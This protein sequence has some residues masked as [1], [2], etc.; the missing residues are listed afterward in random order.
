MVP[1]LVLSEFRNNPLMVAVAFIVIQQLEGHVVVPNVMGRSVGVHPL[2][3]IFGLLIGEAIAGIP[4]VLLSIPMVVIVKE[5]VTFAGDYLAGDTSE[6][7]NVPA[8]DDPD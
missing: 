1:D 6:F 7:D 2:V 5:L 3:V 8:E 4:G